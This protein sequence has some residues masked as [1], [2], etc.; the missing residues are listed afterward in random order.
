MTRCKTISIVLLFTTLFALSSESTKGAL[1]YTLSVNGPAASLAC[2]NNTVEIYLEEFAS[3]G[4]STLLGN[5][6]LGL[7]S[8]FENLS[9]FRVD[10]DY[11]PPQAV[12]RYA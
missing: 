6:T 8:G 9:V 4:E 11:A 7:I 1:I 10:R 12:A 2:V 5:P 3:S